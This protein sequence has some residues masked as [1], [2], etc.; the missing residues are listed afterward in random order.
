L[1]LNCFQKLKVFLLQ[2]AFSSLADLF[3]KGEISLRK[4]EIGARQLGI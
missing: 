4:T 1:P 3:Q 2:L